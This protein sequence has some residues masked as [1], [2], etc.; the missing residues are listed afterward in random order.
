[1]NKTNLSSLVNRISGPASEAWAVGDMATKRIQAGDDIIHLGV[2]DPDLDT[3][4]AVS[5]AAIDAINSGKTHYSLLAGEP[6]LRSGV[7]EHAMTLYGGHISAENTVIFSG[8]QGALFASFLCL[9]EAGDEVIVPEPFYSTSPAVVTAGGATMVSVIFEKSEGYTLNLDKI[10]AAVTD[11]TK[12][13][14]INSPSNPSGAVFDQ[15]TLN[16]LAQYCHENSIWLVS[17]EVYWS[18]TFEG[19]H[20]SAYKNEQYRSTTIVVNSLSKSHAMTGWRVGWAIG[21]DEFT[22]ALTALSQA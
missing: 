20:T 7:A 19:E 12:A 3:P 22:E 16:D 9:T 13:I 5:D 10:K 14:L 21:P 11:K 6:D 2:G 4:A 15:Q 18:V 17:D 1:M 8:T